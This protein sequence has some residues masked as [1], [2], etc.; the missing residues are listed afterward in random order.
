[1]QAP[2]RFGT[3]SPNSKARNPEHGIAHVAYICQKGRGVNVTPIEEQAFGFDSHWD[4]S[5]RALLMAG[6][7]TDAES[8]LNSSRVDLKLEKPKKE[9]KTERSISDQVTGMRLD[10][11]KS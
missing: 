1:M 6:C 7:A 5:K 2:E 4:F 8:N 11:L 10:L 3:H 9:S